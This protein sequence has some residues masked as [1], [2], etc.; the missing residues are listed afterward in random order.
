MKRLTK[1]E[2]E[3]MNLFWDKGAMF[4]RELQGL[5]PEG[6]V[7]DQVQHDVKLQQTFKELVF[8]CGKI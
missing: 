1:R 7:N 5:Y 6:R 2:N 4:V 8:G 3:I